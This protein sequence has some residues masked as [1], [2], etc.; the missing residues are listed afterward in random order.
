MIE[1]R[2]RT[3]V[4]TK[5]AAEEVGVTPDRIRDWNR[6]GLLPD[7]TVITTNRGNWYDL[8]AILDA[9]RA[10]RRLGQKRRSPQV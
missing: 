9:E 6:R 8:D 5:Q 7:E 2:G 10:T 3:W 1:H 4:T